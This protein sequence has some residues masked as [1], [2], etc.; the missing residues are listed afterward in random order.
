MPEPFLKDKRDTI[1]PVAWGDKGVVT[2]LNGSSPKVNIIARLEFELTKSRS[3][4]L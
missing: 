3:P 1:Y 4:T 2:F